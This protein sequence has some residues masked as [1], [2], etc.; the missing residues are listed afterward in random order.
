MASVAG[1]QLFQQSRQRR[2][3]AAIGDRVVVPEVRSV[4]GQ[5]C[6]LVIDRQAVHEGRQAP[7][8]CACLYFVSPRVIGS[9]F[10]LLRRRGAADVAALFFC[11]PLRSQTTFAT[12]TGTIV[13]PSGAVIPKALITVTNLETNYKSTA[14]SNESGTYTVAQ[15]R[16][17]T[18]TVEA[19]AAGFQ[20]F[21]AEKII[22]AARDVRRVEIRL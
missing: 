6:E 18:Y 2:V 1:N 14:E 5:R 4:V 11:A 3:S 13:D 8:W 7:E 15:L 21:R 19:A 12:I 17:G 10:V 9:Y 16:E 20:G 22:L